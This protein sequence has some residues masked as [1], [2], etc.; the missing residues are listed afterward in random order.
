MFYTVNFNQ[1]GYMPENEGMICTDFDHAKDCLIETIESHE[2]P[3]KQ[4]SKLIDMI[5]TWKDENSIKTTNGLVYFIAECEETDASEHYEL[6]SGVYFSDLDFAVIDQM[7]GFYHAYEQ[8]QNFY[9]ADSGISGFIYYN[10]TCAFFQRNKKDIVSSVEQMAS[11]LG[12]S[13]ILEFIES[14][15]CLDGQYSKEEIAR[16][17]YGNEENT[18]IENA[19]AWFALE[20]TLNRMES[21]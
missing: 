3:E 10:E 14:F 15:R 17:I 16:V 20:E 8:S 7:G 19:L 4:E 18:Q 2:L 6:E 11:D 1:S 13:G 9:G 12:D 21:I 5:K